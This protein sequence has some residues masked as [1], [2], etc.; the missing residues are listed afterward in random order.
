MISYQELQKLRMSYDEQTRNEYP[1]IRKVV[2]DSIELLFDNLSDL[3][4]VRFELEIID[5][6]EQHEKLSKEQKQEIIAK[7]KEII[8]QYNQKSL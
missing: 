5:E 2:R 6:V 4:F 1:L 8:S 7:I 3:A